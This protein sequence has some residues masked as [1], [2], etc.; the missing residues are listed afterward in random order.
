MPSEAPCSNISFSFDSVPISAAISPDS[1]IFVGTQQSLYMMPASSNVP[2]KISEI[3]KFGEPIIDISIDS[4]G[5]V[6]AGKTI[7]IFAELLKYLQQNCGAKLQTLGK[8]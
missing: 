1:T 7:K 4:E 5:D 8:K 6:A 3:S 2:T